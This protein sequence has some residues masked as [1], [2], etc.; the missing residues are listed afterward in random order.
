MDCNRDEAIKAK[1]IA[2]K[3]M[4]N[5]DFAGA[6][7]I[8]TKARNL[9][10]NLD[11][12]SQIMT[13]C[14][15]HC[16]AEQ[17]VAD[18]A[19]R[20]LFDM[21]YNAF[22]GRSQLPQQ[23]PCPVR[24][25][26]VVGNRFG[27]SGRTQYA[28][29]NLHP[30]PLQPTQP[31]KEQPT[32]WTACPFCT[33]RYQYYND[34][35]NRAL[36]CQNCFK[37][38]I[39]YNLNVQGVPGGIPSG[40]PC[41]QPAGPQ[42]NV[43]GQDGHKVR[44]Q[45]TSQDF[46]PN[47]GFQ[48]HKAGTSNVN[49]VF[50]TK[51]EEDRDVNMEEKMEGPSRLKFEAERSDD[52]EVPDDVEGSEPMDQ[53]SGIP[54]GLNTRRSARQKRQVIYNEDSDDDLVGSQKHTKPST[55]VENQSEATSKEEGSET[56]KPDGFPVDFKKERKL[57]KPKESAP[58]E[59]ISRNGYAKVEPCKSSREETV[60]LENDE[61]E[62]EIDDTCKS[63]ASIEVPDPEFYV[64]DNDRKEDCIKNDQMWAVYDDTDGMPRFYARIMKV[65]S[66]VFKVKI[67]WLEAKP[68]SPD[69]IKWVDAQLPASCGKF[70]LGKT[71]TIEGVNMFSHM[72][73]Y[74]KSSRGIFVIYPRKGETWAILKNWDLKWSL[75][76]DRYSSYEFD[77]V[78][79]LS[80]YN[81][82]SG[83]GVAYL[84]KVKGFVSLF[85]P[86]NGKAP[87][88]IPPCELYR[89]SHM[90]PSYR[91][92]GKERD[93]I[94]KRSFELD[95]ASLPTNLL[96]AKTNRRLKL[97]LWV[98]GLYQYDEI[99]GDL[100]QKGFDEVFEQ[101]NSGLS[102]A[103]LVAPNETSTSIESRT[104]NDGLVSVGNDPDPAS[105]PCKIE[106]F[107]DTENIE[108][109]N[110]EDGRGRTSKRPPNLLDCML[111]L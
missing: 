36:R 18:R 4:Q 35:L 79:I 15:V 108:V 62:S 25:Q 40:A 48:G 64:F 70:K 11:G 81:E 26:P 61:E 32:F 109:D 55:V 50:K 85:Q 75:D 59:Q 54:E 105:I 92:T 8:V 33:M 110:G 98:L 28:T 52:I 31:A 67:T 68:D 94:P 71:E 107:S 42:Q 77:F 2:E 10:P 13:V 60:S 19:K 17:K 21:K 9:Y 80:D 57:K 38:F 56:V 51:G 100:G 102:F 97:M 47:M 39:A 65:F 76:P 84:E 89:F 1:E 78:E 22:K 101:F 87:F 91:T 14:D 5:K 95:T 49:G 104:S 3:K 30:Q 46:P 93:G 90:V 7:K 37:P 111:R 34:I 24:K 27:N 53:N 74:E 43:V 16:S 23:R 103:P 73:I 83:I 45:S 66:P 44:S 20:S 41:T 63:N 58:L 88:Q 12:I 106:E 29:V 69:E 6:K 72:V 86:K 82:H 96:E 99:G